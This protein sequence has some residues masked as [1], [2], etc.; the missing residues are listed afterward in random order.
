MPISHTPATTE[1]LST[2]LTQCAA[3]HHTVTATGGGTKLSWGNAVTP[4]ALIHTTQLRGVREHSWQDLTATVGAGTTWS[5][6]QNALAQHGQRVALDPLFPDAATVGGVL[7]T[8]DSGLLRMR[9]GGL[10]DLVLGMTIVLADGTVART[11]GKVV[12]NVAGY[13]LPKLLTGSFGTLGIIT[14]ATFRLHPLQTHTATFTVR[15]A[16]IVPLADLMH[17]LVTSAMSLEAMQLR[18]EPEAF[19][20]DIQFGAVPEALADH[21]QRLHSLAAALSIEPSST[22][23][24]YSARESLFAIPN[25]TILKLTTLPTKLSALIAGFA[26]LAASGITAQAVADPVGV[27]TV[28]LVAPPTGLANILEDLRARLHPIGGTAVI[29]QCGTMPLDIDPWNDPQHPPA[30]LDVMRA[31]KQEFDPQRLLNPG[32]FVGGL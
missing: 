4:D 2:I 8:N 17:A 25:A 21:E 16:D 10:R 26:Q 29:L 3:Q 18:N 15:S 12:K 32:K 20:L 22:T 9:Y 11:G 5:A 1:D 24:L 23:S 27:V 14:E 19:A 30:A 7:S 6:M 31:I 28:A 13:D